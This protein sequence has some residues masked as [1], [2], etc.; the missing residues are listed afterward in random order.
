MKLFKSIL[1]IV[2]CVVFILMHSLAQAGEIKVSWQAPKTP[3]NFA[4][5]RIHLGEKSNQYDRQQDVKG[6]Q[7]LKRNLNA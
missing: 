1:T 2:C 6:N 5:Y 7:Q 4:K 3:P